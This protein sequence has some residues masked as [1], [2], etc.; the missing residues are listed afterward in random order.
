[1]GLRPSLKADIA[2][3]G[4]AAIWGATF[5]VVK[6]ALRDASPF[7]FMALRFSLG[8]AALGWFYRRR[9]VRSNLREIRAGCIL[10]IFIGAGFAFQTVGL[11]STTPTRSAFIT[12]LYVVGVPLIAA[13]L[14]LRGLNLAGVTGA[15]VALAG[16]WLLTGWGPGQGSGRGES[17]TIVCAFLFATHI[18]GV[19]IYARRHDGGALAFWQVAFAAAACIAI[20]LT[21]ERAWI[22]PTPGLFAAIVVTGLGATALTLA[23]Q[24]SVQAATTPTRAAII[25]TMEPVFAAATSWAVAGERLTGAA[26]MGAA[27]I[28]AGMM[29]SEFRIAPAPGRAR[30]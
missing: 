4:A 12:G 1:M 25:F 28:I 8:A 24:N 26:A 16:L 19:D 21:A 23:V 2:L 30:P 29:I 18:V 7:A 3:L 27:L 11:L 13:A 20:A 5:V 10:G 22:D 9:I 6:G 15:A 17:L 14:G